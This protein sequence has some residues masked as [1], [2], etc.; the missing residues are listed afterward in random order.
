M[1]I[2]K[3]FAAFRPAV[4]WAQLVAARPYD[5]M[6]RQEAKLEASQNAYSF[7]HVSRADIDLPDDVSEYAPD[8]YAQAKINFEHFRNTNILIQ[9]TSP[10]YYIYAQ[11]MNNKTQ[12]GIVA[13]V[14]VEDYLNNIIKKH[15]FTRP[16]KEKDRIDH[17]TATGL[18]AEPVFLTYKPI[19][20]IDDIVNRI[21]TITRP[22]Y[23]FTTPDGV[24]HTLW[25]MAN[26]SDLVRIEQY[27]NEDVPSLYIADGHHRAEAAAKVC[28]SKRQE[29]PNFTGTE[30][31]NYFMAVLFPS[32]QVTIMDYNRVVK[33]L[34]GLTPEQV[35]EKVSINFTIN[36]APKNPKPTKSHDF[37]MY[38]NKQ[39]YKL[40]AKEGSYN[41]KHP[42]E[43]LDVH[44]LDK[45]ILQPILGIKDQRTD[46]RIDFVGGIR[47]LQELENRV[48]SGEM[49]IAFAL[50]P[51]TVNQLMTV[52]IA[53]E[54]MPPK[55]T[56][57]EPKLRSGLFVYQM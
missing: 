30:P 38:L 31:F 17:I 48:N 5:V 4:K 34:N 20:A 50:Y 55:S 11:T 39:W 35:L 37:G 24:N 33:D 21:V 42:I 52:S 46:S 51:V 47:G 28:L 1:S 13:L 10:R 9:D 45:N 26:I 27:F 32:T 25:K 57:F 6:N 36:S 12:V 2:V 22:I 14:S 18:H 40:T 19:S 8:V 43:S 29:N 15:E 41:A 53:G 3:P 16:V 44:I 23:D 56:W 7:L 49:S 54:V